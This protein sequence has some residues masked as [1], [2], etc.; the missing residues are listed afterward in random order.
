MPQISAL[1]LDDRTQRYLT[2][3]TGKHGGMSEKLDTD[4]E[5]IYF[6][7]RQDLGDIWV[8]DVEWDEQ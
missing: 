8:M 4:G 1:T 5:Y 2:D 6:R 3:F 7:W